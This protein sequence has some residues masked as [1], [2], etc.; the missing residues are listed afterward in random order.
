M[1]GEPWLHSNIGSKESRNVFWT[2]QMISSRYIMGANEAMPNRTK[3]PAWMGKATLATLQIHPWQELEK[4]DKTYFFKQ[5]FKGC[6]TTS[7]KIP[8]VGLSLMK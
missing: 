4:N 2:E 7:G 8:R 5:K 1:G 6:E 3:S